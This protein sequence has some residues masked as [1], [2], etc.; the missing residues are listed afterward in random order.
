MLGLVILLWHGKL[1]ILILSHECTTSIDVTWII[2]LLEATLMEQTWRVTLGKFHSDCISTANN[3]IVWGKSNI[4]YCICSWT[5]P[6]RTGYLGWTESHEPRLLS[7]LQDPPVLEIYPTMRQQNG[8]II[9]TGLGGLT[10]QRQVRGW[11]KPPTL[12]HMEFIPTL[13][14]RHNNWTEDRSDFRAEIYYS[15]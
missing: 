5:L 4:K 15:S 8:W 3:I 14:F 1:P 12:A 13:P 11:V 7:G 6:V 9:G 2:T 10:D